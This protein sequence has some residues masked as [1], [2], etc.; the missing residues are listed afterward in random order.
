MGMTGALPRYQPVATREPREPLA[1]SDPPRSRRPS[2]P[3][4]SRVFTALTALGLAAIL[5]VAATQRPAAAPEHAPASAQLPTVAGAA[6]VPGTP[7]AV[8]LP[9]QQG[10]AAPVPTPGVGVSPPAALLEP[11][12]AWARNATILYTWVNGSDPE[13]RRLREQYGGVFA[14]GGDRDRDNDDLKFSLRTLARHMPWHTGRVVVVSPSPPSFVRLAHP[15]I[16]ASGKPYAHASPAAQTG[17]SDPLGRIEWVDQNALIPKEAQPT[18]SSNVV[19]AFLHRLPPPPPGSHLPD[20]EWIIHCN[21]DYTFPSPL[22]PSDFFTLGGGRSAL[23]GVLWTKNGYSGRGSGPGVLQFLENNQIRKPADYA[24]LVPSQNIWRFSTYNSLDA[25][26]RAYGPAAGLTFPP[27][28]VKHAPFVYSRTALEGTAFKFAAEVNK[29]LTHRFRQYDDVITP[30]LVHA[31]TALD[32]SM[33]KGTRPQGKEDSPLTFAV[34]PSSLITP[35]TLLQK[36]SSNLGANNKI[37][38]TVRDRVA[39]GLKFLAMNDE[40]GTGARAAKA[41]ADLRA[42]YRDMYGDQKSAFEL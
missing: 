7:G 20:S 24:D 15:P 5:L 41:S 33:P 26:E 19:E 27:R 10:A 4:A 17:Q 16:D 13:N 35:A 39:T 32:G 23:P 42:F 38:R 30:L 31:Y 12:W 34:V 29:M 2:E 3:L 40:I 14:V 9:S 21:D 8:G 28:Y 18:F 11:E 6:S 1:P 25:V 37:M 36:W 22:H